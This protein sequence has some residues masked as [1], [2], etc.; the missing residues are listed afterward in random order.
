MTTLAEADRQL[1]HLAGLKQGWYGTFNQTPEG[2]PISSTVIDTARQFA[3]IFI[4]HATKIG[5]PLFADFTL[6]PT[7]EGGIQLEWHQLV[8]EID[9]DPDGSIHF[10]DFKNNVH[11]WVPP[12]DPGEDGEG[13]EF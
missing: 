9:F 1:D 10:Y 2:E 11:M 13:E 12:S 3:T 7:V 6:T 4:E 8:G 5:E